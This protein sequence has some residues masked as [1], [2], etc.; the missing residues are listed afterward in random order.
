[1]LPQSPQTLFSHGTVEEELME[2]VSQEEED[3]QAQV[4]SMAKQCRIFSLLKRHPYDL[5]GGEQQRVALCKVLLQKPE[6]LLL[7]E[8]TKGMD[9]Q[10]KAHFGLLLRTLQKQGLTFILVS[11]DVEF[12]AMYTDR[13]ALLFDGSIVLERET[14]RFFSGNRFYTT[15]ANRMARH[16]LPQAIT[17]DDV[18][19][20][21]GGKTC[22]IFPPPE[23]KEE[24]MPMDESPGWNQIRSKHTYR[25]RT[26]LE[27]FLVLFLIPCT[28]GIGMYGFHD[29]AYAVISIL[30]LIE[31]MLPFFFLLE[32]RKPQARE[33]VL[34]A[35]LCAIG[36]AGRG[37]FAALP[38]VKPVASLVIL[39]GVC[40]GGQ[41]G[42]LVGATTTFLSNFLFGQ[43]PWTPWQMFA[44]GLI[45]WLAGILFREGRIPRKRKLICLF[46][47]ISVFLIY[48]GLLNPASVLMFQSQPTWEMI[49]LAYL[50]GIPFDGIHAVSTILFLF[51]FTRPMLQKL[52]RIRHKY[53][54][55]SM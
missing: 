44:M 7:D 39:S 26:W 28:I 36:I 52:G 20:A 23:E 31:M 24:P 53:G 18:I 54:I 12:C 6:I 25:I 46:G 50:R 1:M 47:G 38:Q 19:A 55:L 3:A 11:H 29:R 27:V 34:L 41:V 13:C 21:C 32:G 16:L 33:V 14:R 17:A 15:A 10:M 9:G 51:F 8:P 40:F 48:G 45:G 5:S 49:V 43:G 22:D 37:V 42:F 35:T 4:K 30:L 2:M